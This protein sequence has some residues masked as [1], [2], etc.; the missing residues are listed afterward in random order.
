MPSVG[1]IMRDI[2]E[3]DLKTEN[4]RKLIY[5]KSRLTE[6]KDELEEFLDNKD[7]DYMKNKVF[8]KKVLLS[9]EIKANN[10]IEDYNDDLDEVL[11]YINNIDSIDSKENK[12]R[13]INVYKAYLYI[14]RNRLSTNSINKNTLKKLYSILSN[15]L[16]SD[17]DLSHMGKFYRDDDVYIFRTNKLSSI[18]DRDVDKGMDPKE[19]D[20]YM[21]N[22][23]DFIKSNNNKDTDT[24]NF[25]ISQIAHFYLVYIHPYFDVNGR[26]AR[27]TALWHLINNKAYPY[28]IF[29]R[30]ISFQKNTYH[31]V[32][33]DSKEF[34][35][36]TFFLNYMLLNV[37][38]E[39]EKEYIMNNIANNTDSHL[40]VKDYQTIEYLLSMKGNITIKD[41]AQFYKRFNGKKKLIDIYN[42]DI[43]PLLDKGVIE[44]V[45]K[46]KTYLNDNIPNIEL[47]LN[48][49]RLDLDKSKIKRFNSSLIKK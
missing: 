11:K 16:L 35:N 38:K 34:Y 17:Y 43:L 3:I 26:T 8:A 46:T 2:K 4:N 25:I 27:T 47:G 29:N 6:L 21:N 10:E 14:L 41:Y 39:L 15:G 20:S 45:R 49:K 5:D 18:H 7:M 44:E 37:K 19:I 40:T 22:L 31:Q 24:E 48:E 32:I 33:Q 28:I 30:A 23:F 12:Q 1:D 42:E 9:R 13:I 36:L